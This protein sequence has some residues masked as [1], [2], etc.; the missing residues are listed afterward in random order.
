MY[1]DKTKHDLKN[2]QK[3]NWKDAHK[4][5][6]MPLR[7]RDEQRSYSKTIIENNF[8]LVNFFQIQMQ[9]LVPNNWLLVGMHTIM[10]FPID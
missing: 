8:K 1:K 3:I 5:W 9:K 10:N 7:K 6:K 2:T 4:N